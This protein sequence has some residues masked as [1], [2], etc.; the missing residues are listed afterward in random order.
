[1]LT[2]LAVLAILAPVLVPLASLVAPAVYDE[3]YTGVLDDKI[4]L[5]RNTE[6]PKIV[7]V[8]GSSVAFGLDSALIERYT[9]MPVINFGLYASLGTK[10]M[11]DLS[12]PHIG[13]GD[14]VILS[15]ELDSQTLS[16]YFSASTT[17]RALDGSFRHLLS[18][19]TEHYSALYGASWDFAAEK[20]SYLMNGLPVYDGIYSAASFNE[21]GDVKA[22]LRAENVMM[23]YYDEANRITLDSSILDPDFADYI[24][25]YIASCRSRGAE[26]WFSWCPMNVRALAEGTTVEGISVFA[27]YLEEQIDAT[28]ISDIDDYIISENY[29]Y[30]TNFHLNDSGVTLRTVRLVEDILLELGDPTEVA[31]LIPDPP[32]LPSYDMFDGRTDEN[33]KYFD[34]VR[35][36]NGSYMISG[37]KDEYKNTH[38]LTVPV[39]Y[40]GFKVT[41]IGARVFDGTGVEALVITADT[42]LRQFSPEA[43]VGNTT[44]SSLYIYYL[45]SESLACPGNFSGTDSDFKVYVPRSSNYSSIY[46]WGDCGLTYVYLDD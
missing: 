16:D 15:P 24:N 4:E 14:I 27:D 17:L 20:L 12:L 28:F 10:L 31:E 3:S 8:G 22:G 37:I 2:V 25:E 30:D 41:Q 13:E 9:G 6:E 46:G 11:L 19:P 40:N 45:D 26:V 44:L 32:E 33:A 38:T 43:F 1:M 35:L 42:N 5:L 29:F 39:A 18:V 7:V 34:F 23:T 36:D 21:Y